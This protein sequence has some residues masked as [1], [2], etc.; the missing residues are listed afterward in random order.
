MMGMK[1]KYSECVIYHPPHPPINSQYL[2]TW[3][4]DSSGFDMHSSNKYGVM[5]PLLSVIAN[6]Q[7]IIKLH[8]K[9]E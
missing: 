3:G 7:R 2:K 9:N 8:V 4:V 1:I 5:L 6:L